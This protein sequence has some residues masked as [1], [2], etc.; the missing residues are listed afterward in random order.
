MASWSSRNAGGSYSGFPLR[1]P[2][3]TRELTDDTSREHL[4]PKTNSMPLPEL[5]R[6]AGCSSWPASTPRSRK[7]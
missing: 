2:S 4:R 3:F 5:Y 7:S 1:E 6:K